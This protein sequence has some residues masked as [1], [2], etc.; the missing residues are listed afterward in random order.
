M[1]DKNDSNSSAYES[2]KN[3]I[4]LDWKGVNL[5]MVYLGR[6]NGNFLCLIFSPP[7]VIHA[8]VFVNVA[9]SVNDLGEVV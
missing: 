4:D 3:C 9:T 7:G 2:T 6:K 5:H 8:S 1:F